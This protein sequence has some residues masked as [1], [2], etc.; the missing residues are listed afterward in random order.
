MWS[1]KS[2]LLRDRQSIPGGRRDM[3]FVRDL[4][5]GSCHHFQASVLVNRGEFVA[6]QSHGVNPV[7]KLSAGGWLLRR[8]VWFSER[9]VGPFGTF[10]DAICL[11]GLAALASSRW[12]ACHP[13]IHLLLNS[14]LCRDQ[15]RDEKRECCHRAKSRRCH[16]GMRSADA[17]RFAAKPM[18]MPRTI[19]PRSARNPDLTRASVESGES[20]PL[21]DRDVFPIGRK[22]PTRHGQSVA[23]CVQNVERIEFESRAFR[24][25]LFVARCRF[26]SPNAARRSVDRL[27]IPEFHRQPVAGGPPR[28]KRHR[29]SLTQRPAPATAIQLAHRQRSVHQRAAARSRQTSSTPSA[30]KA[31]TQ[32]Y[33]EPNRHKPR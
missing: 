25:N 18:L 28:N 20:I 4:A 3:S 26:A 10:R 5:V 7:L 22:N 32:P 1:D 31:Y 27:R 19:S 12:A 15:S 30:R 8:C 11:I 17:R 23:F 6:R 2:P 16:R 9:I 29:P 33:A 24:R 13:V 21:V 14:S